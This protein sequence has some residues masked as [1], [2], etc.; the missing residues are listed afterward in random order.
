M[1]YSMIGRCHKYVFYNW[2]QATNVFRMS[3]KL[4]KNSDLI[5]CKNNNMVEANKCYR[6]E[7]NNFK[8]LNPTESER[9]CQIYCS[10][11]L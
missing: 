7:K 8:I 5:G 11:E 3:P 4:K 6:K 9:D 2:V 10:P 1:M